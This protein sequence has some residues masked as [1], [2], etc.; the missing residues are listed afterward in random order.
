MYIAVLLIL[1]GWALAFR[2]RPVAIYALCVMVAFDLRVVFAEE[3][4]LAATHGRAWTQYKDRVPR[5]LRGLRHR[6]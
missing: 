4:F 3:P 2:S 1:C 6:R 5:W